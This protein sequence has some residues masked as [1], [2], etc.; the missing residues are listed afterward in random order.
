MAT[1]LLKS[2]SRETVGRSGA[3]LIVTLDPGDIIRFREKGKRTTMEVSIGHAYQLAKK[4]T[5][6]K[7]YQE[8][9]AE[10]QAKRKAGK[11]VKRPKRPNLFLSPIYNLKP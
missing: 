5:A 7:I 10:Y 9:M 8:R 11:R 3:P 6:E 1:K 2:I 4:I